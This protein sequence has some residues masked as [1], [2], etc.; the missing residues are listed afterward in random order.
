MKKPITLLLFWIVALSSVPRPIH[1]GTVQQ[2]DDVSLMLRKKRLEGGASGPPQLE[3]GWTW[4]TDQFTSCSEGAS[5]TCTTPTYG[6]AGNFIVTSLSGD[7]KEYCVLTG[8][9]VTISSVTSYLSGGTNAGETWT[10]PSTAHVYNASNADNVAC[11]QS[12]SGVAG[13]EK[14]VATL[15]GTATAAPSGGPYLVYRELK[16]PSGY[17]AS[18]DTSNTASSGSCTNCTGASLTLADT[19][20][21]TE[22]ADDSGY[23]YA[24]NSCP[25]NWFVEGD[26]AGCDY[27][28]APSGSLS[29]PTFAFTASQN[30]FTNVAMAWKA[31]AGKFT[32]PSPVFS[33]ANATVPGSG[34]YV[35]CGPTCTIT[36][37]T[38]TVENYLFIPTYTEGAAGYY[39]SSCSSSMGTCTVPTS[40]QQQNLSC[41]EIPITTSGTSV[42]VTFN[43]STTT[44]GF[45]ALELART[46]GTWTVDAVGCNSNTTTNTP[47][48]P[49]LTLSGTN[50]AIVNWGYAIG[51]IAAQQYF[52]LPLIST[53]IW[54]NESIYDGSIG[55]LLNSVN[56]T[57]V[58]YAFPNPSPQNSTFCEWAVK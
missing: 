37:P 33:V 26:D 6:G 25:T 12:V 52:Y 42:S 46:S 21:V 57:A 14:I 48:G 8:N 34:D 28:N 22:V 11:A 2:D 55:Y 39:P 50:D 58:N 41:M 19:D 38:T 30:F 45:Y 24:A 10:E 17:A 4:I 7:V 31:T 23:N 43:S 16:P 15:S 1:S 49:S 3:T 51:G 29:A 27:I 9:N 20:Y 47:S 36:V 18:Y 44:A 56:G 54:L 13:V 5:T 40:C 32:I 53:A 35:S